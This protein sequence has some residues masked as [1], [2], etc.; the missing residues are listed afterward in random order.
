MVFSAVGSK[1][2]DYKGG[3]QKRGIRP[4]VCV[5]QNIVIQKIQILFSETGNR[6]AKVLVRDWML[7]C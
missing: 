5:K 4:T 1:Q 7:L 6:Q 3:S 2:V